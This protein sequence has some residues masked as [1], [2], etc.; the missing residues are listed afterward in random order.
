MPLTAEVNRSAFDS[1]QKAC[2]CYARV[3]AMSDQ[4]D[5]VVLVCGGAGG[6]GAEIARRIARDGSRVVI[7]DLNE[8]EA[9]AQSDGIVASGGEAIAVACDVTR[10]ELCD[11]AAQAAIDRFGRLDGVVNCAGISMP[12]DSIS[13]APADWARMIDIQLN[14]TLSMLRKPARGGCGSEGARWCSLPAST[15]KRHSPGERRTARRRPASRCSQR[16]WQSSGPIG[17]SESTPSARRMSP[18]R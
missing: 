10:P 6:I 2:P 3:F 9:H 5:K 7:A 1:E 16:C 15:P 11:R 18:L 12:I 14:G 13:I 8:A 17:K 4:Q